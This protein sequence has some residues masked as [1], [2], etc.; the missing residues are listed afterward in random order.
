MS[1]F[2][3]RIHAG[4]YAK[5]FELKCLEF[6]RIAA[7][8]LELTPADK[9]WCSLFGRTMKRTTA[10]YQEPDS[11]PPSTISHDQ[12]IALI[13]KFITLNPTYGKEPLAAK[14]MYTIDAIVNNN[15]NWPADTGQ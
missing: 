11:P 2:D 4:D 9:D 5:D 12:L 6:T 14:T 1:L 3:G 10:I 15:W 8:S 7:N 13:D